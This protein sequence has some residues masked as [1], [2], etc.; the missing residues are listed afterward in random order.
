[1]VVT[2]LLATI[3]VD[4]LIGFIFLKKIPGTFH[5]YYHHGYKKY[6][7]LRANWG[8]GEY[9]FYT[10]SLN[11]RDRYQREVPLK[12]N[13]YRILFIGDSFTE[14]VGV[15]YE[16]TFVGLVEQQKNRSQVEVLNA[17]VLSYSPKLYYL[18]LK[19]LLEK[20]KLHINEVFV[21]ID[22]SD[23]QD[24][25][26]YEQ[27]VSLFQTP[28]LKQIDFY[29]RKVSFFY[30]QVRMKILNYRT[31]A[32]ILKILQRTKSV[33][34]KDVQQ[35]MFAQLSLGTFS[36]QYYKER[37]KWT[38]DQHAFLAWGKKGVRLAEGNMEKLVNLCRINKI[39]LN[40]AVYP[41]PDQIRN[42]EI[43]SRQITIW[44]DFAERHAEV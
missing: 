21:F 14:G 20:E 2:V 17:G 23:I 13:K 26:L 32:N 7:A 43:K 28:F 22:I 37:A 39:K 1:M 16:K 38:Y 19:Y 31:K 27:F 30:Y 29:L 34:S 6:M 42:R 25:I 36:K 35:K 9:M 8:I 15:P 4:L 40:I 41:W 24:E 5:P 11:M 33:Q 12:A 3:L 10:N 18:R 44:Q